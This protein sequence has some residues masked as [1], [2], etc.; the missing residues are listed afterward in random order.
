MELKLELSSMLNTLNDVIHPTVKNYMSHRVR[1][2]AQFSKLADEVKSFTDTRCGLWL[3]H[4]QK[5]LPQRYSEGQVEY[6][7]K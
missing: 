1:A 5:I 7:A 2:V 4:K 6:F 3:D